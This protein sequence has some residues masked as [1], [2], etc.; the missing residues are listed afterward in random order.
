MKETYQRIF[1][2][3]CQIRHFIFFSLAVFIVFA[4]L[5]Y[6]SAKNYPSYFQP[7]LK[8]IQNLYSPYFQLSPFYQFLF[9]FI[10]NTFNLFLVV[11]SG[12][13]FGVFPFFSLLSNGFSLGII[14]FFTKQEFSFSFFISGVLPHGILEIPVLILT[15]A[16]GLKIGQIF[17][18][19][20][21]KKREKDLKKEL[22]FA[23]GIFWRFF[24]P[25]LLL[26]AFI[27]VFFTAKILLGFD[28]RNI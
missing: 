18:E 16:L 22:I 21:F 2:Y 4:F 1:N 12:I 5:G 27:E 3:F 25:L 26:A 17:F 15:G 10:H 11:L 14:A 28:F 19:R 24:I 20:I 8:E 23:L 7:I 9:I 6:F 13:F